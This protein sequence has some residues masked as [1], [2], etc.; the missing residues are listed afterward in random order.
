M[1]ISKNF[2]SLFGTRIKVSDFFKEMLIWN[3]IVMQ[4]NE[5][6]LEVFRCKSYF[7]LRVLQFILKHPF[8][9]LTFQSTSLQETV[10]NSFLKDIAVWNNAMLPLSGNGSVFASRIY[11][12]RHWYINFIS[13]VNLFWWKVKFYQI[14]SFHSE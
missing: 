10:Y 8:A 7:I 12:T 11:M 9:T 4:K 1:T 2:G 6:F 5:Q 13:Q 14:I 3:H